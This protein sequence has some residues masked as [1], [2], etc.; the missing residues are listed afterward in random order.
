MLDRDGRVARWHA[1][2]ARISGR[3]AQQAIGRPLG[4][5]LSEEDRAAGLAERALATALQD[6]MFHGACTLLREDGSRFVADLVVDAVFEAADAPAGFIVA[7]SDTTRQRQ[8]VERH[9]RMVRIDFVTGIANRTFFM[10]KLEEACARLRRRGD[11]FSL[12]MLDLDRFKA[13]N[14]FHGHPA[15]DAL[16][17]MVAE[18]LKSSVRET[19]ALARIGGDEFAIIQA[20]ETNQ[21]YAAAKLADRIVSLL[22][23][24]FDVDGTEVTIGS[25]IGIVLAPSDA[26]DPAE[27]IKKA[28]VALHRMKS[29][30]RE[31]YRFFDRE[32][33]A[34]AEAR[35]QLEN[36]LRTALERDEIEV[37]YQPVVDVVTARACAVQ[38][39]PRWHHA[40]RGA[41]PS[42]SLFRWPKRRG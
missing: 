9:A 15:G 13:V 39:R 34:A 8:E 3:D 24:P 10:E 28:D 11:P 22:A 7:I 42:P 31:D 12:F 33:M 36:D 40:V 5:L 14:D 20:G 16:L 21:Q 18:R 30:G 23:T 1:S 29:E 19:D 26:S 25:S 32:M 41:V 37:E 6:G 27:L 4:S 2:A 35:R 38:A 17:A